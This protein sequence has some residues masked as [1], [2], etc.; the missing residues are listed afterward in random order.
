MRPGEGKAPCG[1]VL[2]MDEISDDFPET[3]VSVVNGADDIVNPTAPDDPTRPI[4]GM[5]VR[6]ALRAPR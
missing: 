3:D 5:R 6:L 4:A 1:S 2:E